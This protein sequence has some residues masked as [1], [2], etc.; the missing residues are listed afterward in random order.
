M[1]SKKLSQFDEENH[2]FVDVDF[3]DAPYVHAFM[4]FPES[5]LALSH[6]SSFPVKLSTAA[7]YFQNLIDSEL[8]DAGPVYEASVGPV[9]DPESFLAQLK[10]AE[11]ISRV[12][13]TFKRENPIDASEIV[14]PLKKVLKKIRG[15][16]GAVEIVGESLDRDDVEEFAREAASNDEK[17]SALVK[18]SFDAK[19]VTKRLGDNTAMIGTAETDESLPTT[20]G[21]IAVAA[22]VRQKYQAVRGTTGKGGADDGG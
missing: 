8:A 15:Q 3:A 19:P 14:D 6:R 20:D 12:R 21:M 9:K 17:A 7:Y 4:L 13:F 18:S 1:S 10:E 5:V 2:A 11:V 16:R 22:A